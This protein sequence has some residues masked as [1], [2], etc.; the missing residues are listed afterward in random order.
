M[1]QVALL[2]GRQNVLR[3]LSLFAGFLLAC[4]IAYAQNSIQSLTGSVQSGA[5]VIRIETAEP[6]SAVPSGFTIQSPARI[7][8]DFPGVVNGIGRSALDIG[9][10][11]I[12]SANVVQAVDRTRVVINLKQPSTYQAKLDGKTLLLVLDGSSSASSAPVAQSAPAA[13]APS[14]NADPAA[15]KDIDFRRGVGNSGRVV[16]EL[17]NSQTGVDIRQQGKDLVVDFLKTTLPEGLRRKLDVTDFGTPVQSVVT[18][19]VGDRVRML[20]TPTGLWEHSAYQSDNQFV[21]EIR[22]QKLDPSKLTQGP[23]YNGEKLSL[24]FQNIEVRSLLQVIA[25]FTNFNVVTSD[26]VS[27]AV[28]LRLKDVPWDQAL[29]IILQAK[30]LGMRKSGNVLWIAPK[31]EIAAREKQELE[32]KASVES[33]ETLRTQ[34]FQMNY[35]KASDIAGQITGAGA[36]GGGASARI[37]SP[38]GSV[39]AEPRTNQLFV[40]DIP[41]KLE[42][43][44]QLIAKLDIPVRQVLIEARIVE[45]DDRF[46]RSLGVRLGG[47]DLRGVRGGEAGYPV[48]GP[49]RV[50]IGGSYNAVSSTTVESENTL[51]T[52]NTSFV[53]LP[54]T[55][56]GGFLPAAF[57][58]SLFSSAANRFLNLEISALEA[59]GRGKIV[60][61]PRVV[62]ADQVKA[63]I[64]QGTEFPYQTATSS[65]AT[66]VAFRKANLKL[67]VTPQ[68]TPEGNI[69]LDVDINKDS[70]GE[71]TAAGIAI[72]TKHVQ[73][74]VLVENGGTVVIGGIFT[75]E[76]TEDVA[77]VPLFGDLPIV[78]NLFK[79]KNKSSRKQELL[80]FITPR[81][82][83]EGAMARR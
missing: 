75:E 79:N 71:T 42:Q 65:G 64:E 16:V 47:S 66:A 46:G 12:R 21:L 15:L 72:N 50:A 61:S 27:G 14:G 58:V 31:D 10:G 62:T 68:I 23:G 39:I 81:S 25:D 52:V 26:S 48:S 11:N 69:I 82:I 20:V 4:T 34:G 55:G 70:R 6:L 67:E 2:G 78:G 54:S 5:E 35:A 41:S 60:S 8:L 28:T 7:A 74:Q 43:V 40:T 1:H 44:Q 29:D 37:L 73:T 45:A 22:E 63:L 51:D 18:S 83:T 32:S 80:I 9:Q 59:D 53:N 56:A 76:E 57:A 38:R 17:A 24:N 36:A 77:K 49:N 3:G 33:L 19:Q 30:G 13:F